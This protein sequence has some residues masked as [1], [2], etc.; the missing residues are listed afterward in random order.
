MTAL[1]ERARRTGPLVSRI[2]A[3]LLGGYGIAVLFSLAVLALPISKPQAVLT[4][5]LASF[6]IYAGA[7]IWVFAVRRALTAWIGLLIVAAALAP[8]AWSG[9]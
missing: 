3:A 5:Q 2:V 6:A 4:G 8:L 7:V 9:S 1:A